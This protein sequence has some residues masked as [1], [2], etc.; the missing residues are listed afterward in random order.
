MQRTLLACAALAVLA[1]LPAGAQTVADRVA[2]LTK[3]LELTSAQQAQAE[4]IFTNEATAL[5]AAKDDA[6]AAERTKAKATASAAFRAILT[7]EQQAKYSKMGT[8]GAPGTASR[9]VGGSH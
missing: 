3:A 8:L 1:I 2:R 5:A 4:T 9:R 7:A 6:P